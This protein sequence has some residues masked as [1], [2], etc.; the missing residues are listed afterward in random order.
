MSSINN[1][2]HLRILNFSQKN[3]KSKM[4]KKNGQISAV[5]HTTGLFEGIF[6]S[7]LLNN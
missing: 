7:L 4:E 5:I 2:R 1:V 3:K 6:V